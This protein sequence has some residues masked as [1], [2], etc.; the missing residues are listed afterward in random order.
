M[1]KH[2]IMGLCL[3]GSL[4]ACLSLQTYHSTGQA[5][6]SN[7]HKS[8]ILSK[9]SSNLKED[10]LLLSDITQREKAPLKSIQI[11]LKEGISAAEI[12]LKNL[13]E[14]LSFNRESMIIEGLPEIKDWKPLEEYRSFRTTIL[15]KTQEL[16]FLNFT[17]MR[18]SDNDGIPDLSDSDDDGDGFSDIEERAEGSNPKNPEDKP[19]K[20]PQASKL[21]LAHLSDFSLIEGT[22]LK[23]LPIDIQPQDALVELTGLPE[24]L[25]FDPTTK[26]I[27]GKLAP[28]KW[29]PQEYSRSFSLNLQAKKGSEL[30]QESFKLHVLRK[31]GTKLQAAKAL[32]SDPSSKDSSKSKTNISTQN[33]DTE[34]KAL[35]NSTK[36]LLSLS[37]T[38]NKTDNKADNK[39]NNNDAD[40]TS[41]H[42]KES[43]KQDA[44]SKTELPKT[45]KPSSFMLIAL[46]F[47][48]SLS[49]GLGILKLRCR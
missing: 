15:H 49:L 9:D 16:G 23:A 18:D 31:E 32:S 43:D 10:E 8:I 27:K 12:E 7:A 6:A 2:S 41:A 45:G 21:Q 19:Q 5:F 17:I 1:K 14:G 34:D 4:G 3:V 20:H 44:A 24:G 13:P 48:G 36:D 29:N 22:E 37:K 28:L 35:T 25:S 33:K 39:A 38:D 26:E 42:K 46:A 11:Q 47:L 30:I 40:K